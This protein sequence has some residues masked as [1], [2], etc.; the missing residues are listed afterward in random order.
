MTRRQRARKRA[1]KATAQHRRE[2]AAT[3]T[4]ATKLTP[5]DKVLRYTATTPQD[6]IDRMAA[7]EEALARWES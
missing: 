3:A 2:A 7:T 1:I 5:L 6:E 4:L